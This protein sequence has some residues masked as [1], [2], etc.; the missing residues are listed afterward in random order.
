M[1]RFRD[2]A[3]F[4]VALLSLFI[5]VICTTYNYNLSPV[6]S[7]NKAVEVTIKKGQSIDSIIKMLDNKHLIR[8]PKVFKVYIAIYKIKKFDSGTY[9]LK[10]SMDSKEIVEVLLNR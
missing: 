5:I 9:K 6:N 8:N 7:S 10:S 3:L 4:L 2:M 1:R